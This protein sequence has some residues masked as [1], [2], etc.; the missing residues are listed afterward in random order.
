MRSIREDIEKEHPSIQRSDVVVF[1]QVAEFVTAFQFYKCSAS[2]V[3]M[4]I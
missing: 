3:R 4:I 1:F 2:K